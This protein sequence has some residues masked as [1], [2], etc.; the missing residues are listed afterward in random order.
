MVC[1]VCAE[2]HSVREIYVRQ[3]DSSANKS[4]QQQNVLIYL[5]A[6]GL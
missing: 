1:S 3:T 4:G 6:D 2:K 5:N